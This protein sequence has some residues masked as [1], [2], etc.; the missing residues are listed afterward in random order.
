MGRHYKATRERR[1]VILA[2]IA[3]GE[4]TPAE[5]AHIL[6]TS[7]RTVQRWVAAARINTQAARLA[8]L[9][10]MAWRYF[11]GERKSKEDKRA[12]AILAKQIW[13]DIGAR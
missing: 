5:A 12:E 10:R 9:D 13:D 2:A 7:A 3:R 1:R 11:S 8:Y 6:E 4:I